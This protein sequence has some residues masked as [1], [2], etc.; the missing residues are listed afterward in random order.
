M[1]I[2]AIDDDPIILDLLTQFIDSMDTHELTTAESGQDAIDLLNHQV[3]T[4]FDC[5]L[6]DIQMPEM[7]GVELTK[8][9]RSVQKYADTPIVMLTAMSEKR[10]IDAA[11]A[12]GATD[13]VTKPFELVELKARLAVVDELVQQRRL[14]STRPITENDLLD[15][16]AG[17]SNAGPIELFQPAA[18]R[19]VDNLITHIAMEN[20]VA[21]LSRGALFG[22]S[23][24]AFAVRRIEEFHQSLN[25]ADFRGLL[26]N[27]AK[28][29]SETL[30]GHQFLMSYAGNGI[31]VCVTEQGWRPDLDKVRDTVNLSFAQREIRSDSG[32]RLQPRVVVG[33]ATRLVWKT[34]S[35]LM[36]ALAQSHSSAEAAS[37]D[38]EG[39]IGNI[40]QLEHRF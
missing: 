22:S 39:V 11:F 36:D 26:T 14:S 35:S 33:E 5:F 21:Q 2:I 25:G 27:V 18:I 16:E 28:N 37:L 3:Q 17:G 12:A 9:I 38:A 40:R 23:T 24:F 30:I 7:D 1:R 29:I 15:G 31:F 32:E 13:Y 8:Y 34:N 19:G 6:V 10:Y 20:Y 4:P